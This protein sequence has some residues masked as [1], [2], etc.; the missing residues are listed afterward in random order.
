MMQQFEPIIYKPYLFHRQPV[1]VHSFLVLER[2]HESLDD[3][4]N[5]KHTYSRAADG[6][7]WRVEHTVDDRVNDAGQ[8]RVQYVTSILCIHKNTF[9]KN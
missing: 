1:G 6:V 7:Y 5:I 8:S 3:V 4:A 2:S 9:R